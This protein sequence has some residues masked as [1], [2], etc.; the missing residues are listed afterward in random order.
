VVDQYS[1]ICYNTCIVVK[2]EST[3]DELKIRE[4]DGKF[5]VYFNGPFGQCAYQSDPFDTLE[6]AEAFRQEQL[7]SADFGDQ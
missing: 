3:V 4:D 6:A 1:L 2:K 7:D 5:Y